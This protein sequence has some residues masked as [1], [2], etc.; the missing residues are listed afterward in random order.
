MKNL[1]SVSMRL[2]HGYRTITPNEFVHRSQIHFPFQ[3]HFIII[4]PDLPVPILYSRCSQPVSSRVASDGPRSLRPLRQILLAGHLDSGFAGD[5]AFCDGRPLIGCSHCD[6][7]EWPCVPKIAYA[8][9]GG[10]P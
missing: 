8:C 4:I 3:F 5:S 10:A 2:Q 9:L 1:L 6:G 7:R